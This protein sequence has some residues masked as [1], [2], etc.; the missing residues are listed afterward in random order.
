MS[1]EEALAR[2]LRAEIEQELDRLAQLRKDAAG[3]PRTDELYSIR[4][5]GS[6]LHD[7]Y[8][9]IERIFGRI[10]DELDGGCPRGDPSHQQLPNSM[11]LAVPGVRPAIVTPELGAELC[12]FLGFRHR[13]RHL[14]GFELYGARRAPLEE[15]FPE[16]LDAFERQT[17]A[18]LDWLTGPQPGNSAT[19]SR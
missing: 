3:A 1:P 8:S 17:R 6:I 11:T 19:H 5:R 9:E 13:F 4:A 7:L 16:V 10:A 15:R 12:D 2:R 14:Y 18:F